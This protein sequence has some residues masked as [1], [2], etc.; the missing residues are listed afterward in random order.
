MTV[1]GAVTR[2]YIPRNGRMIDGACGV[3]KVGNWVAGENTEMIEFTGMM[4]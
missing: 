4:R 1:G 3:G 2:C